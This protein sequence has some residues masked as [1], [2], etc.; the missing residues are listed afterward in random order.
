MN[1]FFMLLKAET[2]A[3]NDTALTVVITCNFAEF[4]HANARKHRES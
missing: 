2:C 1:D 4:I 3:G